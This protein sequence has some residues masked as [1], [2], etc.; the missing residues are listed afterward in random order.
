[1]KDYN[2]HEQTLSDWNDMSTL[3]EGARTLLAATADV[4]GEKV[5]AARNRLAATLEGAREIC[6]S[7]RQQT[8]DGVKAADRTVRAHP[9]QAIGIALGAGALI[10]FLLTRRD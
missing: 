1:M 8:A 2:D 6:N 9:Y 7:V 10:G 4:P 5:G 3:T